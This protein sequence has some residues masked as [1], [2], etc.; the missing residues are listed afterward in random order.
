MFYEKRNKKYL[1]EVALK[2]S[3]KIEFF[4]DIPF[5]NKNILGIIILKIPRV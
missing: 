5:D 4:S 2:S 3:R 1:I